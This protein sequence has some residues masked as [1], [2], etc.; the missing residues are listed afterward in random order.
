VRVLVVGAT[1]F[2][3]EALSKRLLTQG[4]TVQI[5]V[6]NPDAGRPLAEAGARVVTGSIGDPNQIAE[7]ADN[8]EVLFHCAGESSHHAS[9]RV[10][11]WINAAGTENVIQAARYVGVK[12]VVY[13]SCADVSLLNCHRVHWREDRALLTTPLDA[14]SRSKLL[15]EELAL[16][17]S[18]RVTEVTAL[19]PAWVWGPGERRLLPEL[20]L[21]AQKGPITL[22]GNGRN[23]I[24]T[25][26]ID[27]LIDALIAAAQSPNVAQNVY[28]ISDGEFLESREFFGMLCKSLELSKPREGSFA[29]AYAVAWFRELLRAQGPWRADVILRGRTSLFDTLRATHDLGYQPR[30]AVSEGMETVARWVKEMG[31]PAAIART[32]RPPADDQSVAEQIAQAR[33]AR[34]G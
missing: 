31:G 17:A 2:V 1:G 14:C 30:V 16:L 21:E 32:W 24:A 4:A 33:R 7:A 3:G 29:F 8:C 20:C 10:L 15:A 34:D 28:Y 12:R 5:M 18:S 26:Y 13:L 11:Q 9:E 6:R 19:R 27:N 22:F 23:L 25:V